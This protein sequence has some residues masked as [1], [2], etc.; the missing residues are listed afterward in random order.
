M[1]RKQGFCREKHGLNIYISDMV[2]VLENEKPGIGPPGFS[3]ARIKD[4]V[5]V[6]LAHPHIYS[7]RCVKYV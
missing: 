2:T 4:T 1:T 6:I 3:R 7:K 5:S